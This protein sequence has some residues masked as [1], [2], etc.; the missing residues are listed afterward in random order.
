LKSVEVLP[1]PEILRKSLDMALFA[2]QD[3]AQIKLIKIRWDEINKLQA[4]SVILAA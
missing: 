4:Q 2:L 3:L 1:T